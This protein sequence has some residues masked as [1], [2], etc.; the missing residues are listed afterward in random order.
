MAVD[1]TEVQNAAKTDPLDI[2][3]VSAIK[4]LIYELASR[5]EALFQVF[6]E[7]FPPQICRGDIAMVRRYAISQFKKGD[8]LIYKRD[9]IKFGR[10]LK[11]VTSSRGLEIMVNPPSPLHE[12]E[13]VPQMD[14]IG[15]VVAVE[16][17]GKRHTLHNGAL[18]SL[19]SLFGW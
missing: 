9:G 2:R 7:D 1:H 11:L 13:M 10:F 3:K 18:G 8:I 14:M 6:D 17:K 5:Q 19:L 4:T 15:R 16:R 12:Q